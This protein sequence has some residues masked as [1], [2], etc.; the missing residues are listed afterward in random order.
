LDEINEYHLD[1]HYCEFFDVM[2]FLFNSDKKFA[3]FKRIWS[4]YSVMLN[5]LKEGDTAILQL[6]KQAEDAMYRGVCRTE[7]I[8]AVDSGDYIDDSAVK[9]H[10][11]IQEYD[12]KSYL[13]AGKLLKDIGADFTLP[14]DYVKS[15]P[16]LLSFM[17]NYKLKEKIEKYFKN[18]PDKVNMAKSKLLWLDT[19]RIDKYEELPKV[20]A[21]LE[22]LMQ[23]SFSNES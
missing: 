22:C 6:K 3:E 9:E 14:V 7:R 10:L 23:N 11:A 20:N 8:G 15:S 1:E 18:N 16:Y 13:D 21:R 12:I 17:R 4:N 19:S 5:E 2:K